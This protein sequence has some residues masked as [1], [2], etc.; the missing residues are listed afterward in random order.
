M[1]IHFLFISS[2]GEILSA[3][4]LD[5]DICRDV[6]D[7]EPD[8]EEYSLEFSRLILVTNR[9]RQPKE[10]VDLLVEPPSDAYRAVIP[11]AEYLC[12]RGITVDVWESD[13]DGSFCRW[14]TPHIT[15]PMLNAL[16]DEM[17]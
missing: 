14:I 3:S 10:V 5:G 9:G 11:V 4:Q 17:D 1:S 8:G 2:D 16:I 15:S 6:L 12:S 7:R 13:S